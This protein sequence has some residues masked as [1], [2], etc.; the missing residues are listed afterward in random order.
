MFYLDRE[1]DL[2]IEPGL[3]FEHTPFGKRAGW[4]SCA[5]TNPARLGLIIL[6][7]TSV[8]LPETFI[9]KSDR[10]YLTFGCGLPVLS[11][12][13][14]GIRIS[15]ATAHTSTRIVFESFLRGDTTPAEWKS[16]SIPLAN[17][18]GQSG[19]FILSCDSGPQKISDADWLAV[20]EF[21]I[22]NPEEI[23]IVRAQNQELVQ[24]E[25]GLAHFSWI[26]SRS[27]EHRNEEIPFLVS[28][29]NAVRKSL[30]LREQFLHWQSAMFLHLAQAPI[31]FAS[32]LKDFKVGQNL[33]ILCVI[34]GTGELEHGILKTVL[35]RAHVTLSHIE[36]E[37]LGK[38]AKLFSE[39]SGCSIVSGKTVETHFTAK[40]F[41]LVLS[42]SG[43]HT[44]SALE[45]VVSHLAQSMK[46][47]GELLIVGEY[48]GPNGMR[49]DE[50]SYEIA[51]RF[52]S[53]WPERLRIRCNS[54]EMHQADNALAN[55]SNESGSV[56]SED[57]ERALAENFR[58][59]TVQ[60][61][62]TFCWKLFDEYGDN[63]DLSNT[64]DRAVIEA[65]AQ[66]DAQNQLDK[67]L[68]PVSFDAIYRLR[69]ADDE[70][71]GQ[72]THRHFVCNICGAFNVVPVE[73]L[74]RETRS[75]MKCDSS[76]RLR[77]I[78]GI[79]SQYF[80]G[81]VMPIAEFP[82]SPHIKGMGTSDWEVYA[83]ALAQKFDYVNTYY[84]QDP[85]LDITDIGSHPVDCFDFITSTDVFEHVLP[86]VQR[87]FDN[88]WKLLK[89][90]GVFVFS[91]P[92]SFEAETLEH[93]PDIYDF[94]IVERNGRTILENRTR[95]GEAQVFE[96]LVFH[97]GVG[98][99]LEMRVF[100]K[101]AIVKHLKE[102]GFRRMAFF[103]REVMSAGLCWP[104]EWS[105]PLIAVK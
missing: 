67:S 82:L 73:T 40:S 22:A 83:I 57:I 33:T 28:F 70:N 38:I 62:N 54:L 65:A 53:L 39:A 15:F 3:P 32:Y 105:L 18:S 56:R 91:V 51:N 26:Y 63:F 16:V 17:Y 76:L 43:F 99:T 27:T 45:A 9:K 13:G 2:Q 60:R 89:P 25:T 7:D 100:S 4:M 12:D 10:L 64:F 103:D 98:K 1:S 75:C 5:H 69:T 52:F 81:R 48:V 87:A 8:T 77:T 31:N 66:I 68:V 59:K 29:P 61:H 86:P 35:H 95:T 93:F 94:N 90:G 42:I 41:D 49:L 80:F 24:Y 104:I 44:N 72:E 71:H 97:G 102:A 47:D 96:N 78:V 19:R 55:N 85:K 46:T 58:C 92:Y 88:A 36:S 30:S 79:L 74:T 50:R 23:A 14:L 84:H 20:G 34:S 101:S 6:A 21:A 11:S 37:P